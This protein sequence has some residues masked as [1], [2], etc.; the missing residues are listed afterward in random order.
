MLK[1]IEYYY[2]ILSNASIPDFLAPFWAVAA[3]GLPVEELTPRTR[4]GHTAG[5]LSWLVEAERITIF[6]VWTGPGT[7]TGARTR[8]I[9]AHLAAASQ[10][11]L[12][13]SSAKSYPSPEAMDYFVDKDTSVPPD[14]LTSNAGRVFAEEF[15]TRTLVYWRPMKFILDGVNHL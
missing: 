12:K 3:A 4:I 9:T 1:A 2:D 13:A 8:D 11:V 10:V 5:T 14:L 15:V 7:N 6:A